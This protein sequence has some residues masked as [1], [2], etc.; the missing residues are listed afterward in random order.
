[1]RS[2]ASDHGASRRAAAARRAGLA[3]R[4][5]LRHLR[6]VLE[7]RREMGSLTLG[8]DRALAMLN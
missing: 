5:G 1:M 4:R 6:A 8:A 2:K 3:P 7:Q